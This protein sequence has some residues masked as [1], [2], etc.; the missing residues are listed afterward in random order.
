M[1]SIPQV[2]NFSS[3]SLVCVSQQ[4]AIEE[5]IMTENSSC[6]VLAHSSSLLNQPLLGRLGMCGKKLMH[7]S[8][9]IKQRP[10]MLES[11]TKSSLS[12]TKIMIYKSHWLFLLI[13]RYLI[14]KVLKK[15]RRRQSLDSILAIT[16]FKLLILFQLQFTAL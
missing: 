13:T 12:S 15:T 7:N 10:Q 6:F 16:K 8:F 14:R 2:E 3:S 9:F 1:N 4:F 5:V 11:S